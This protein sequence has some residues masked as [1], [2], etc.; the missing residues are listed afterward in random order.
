[1]TTNTVTILVVDDNRDNR[2]IL[3]RRLERH[4]YEVLIAED[5]SEVL[6]I[7]NQQPCD[8]VLLDILMREMDGMETLQNIRKQHSIKQLPVM[9]VS[10]LTDAKSMVDA[11]NSGANDYITKP[12]DTEVLLARIQTQLTL[13][14]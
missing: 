9:M 1:M 11:F 5:G 12:I 14:R 8:L 2:N 13:C 3:A 7:L 10:A 6:D 4:G